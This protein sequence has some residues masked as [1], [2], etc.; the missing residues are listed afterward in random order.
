MGTRLGTIKMNVKRRILIKGK[1]VHSV[2]FGDDC[3]AEAGECITHFFRKRKK[4]RLTTSLH[5]TDKILI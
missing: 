2:G 1:K 3:D 4:G 5:I